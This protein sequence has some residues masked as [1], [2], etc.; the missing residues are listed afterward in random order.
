MTDLFPLQLWNCATLQLWNCAGRG[1]RQFWDSCSAARAGIKIGAAAGLNNSDN[2]ESRAVNALRLACQRIL[3]FFLNIFCFADFR[4]SYI[5]KV[6]YCLYIIVL[7]QVVC[8][9]W[10]KGKMRQLGRGKHMH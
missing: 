7:G 8:V 5:A 10:L 2:P 9:L 1:P 3:V 4:D 6:F